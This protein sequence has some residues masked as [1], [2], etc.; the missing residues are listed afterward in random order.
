MWF[1]L[2]LEKDFSRGLNSVLH[3]LACGFRQNF[4]VLRQALLS[5][6][7]LIYP[8]CL[9][10]FIPLWLE[11]ILPI[12][13]VLLNW[14][15]FVLWPNIWSVLKNIPDLLEKNVFCY[16]WRRNSIYFNLLGILKYLE[17]NLVALLTYK[18]KLTYFNPFFFL[19]SFSCSA[20]LENFPLLNNVSPIN[21][22]I[23]TVNLCLWYPILVS[24]N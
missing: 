8:L 22:L 12:I 1:F 13:S 18:T 9:P 16:C 6:V 20:L 17:V 23:S 4:L 7:F 11:N 5:E 10:N 21:T 15:T 24:I 2:F 19:Y 14:L 3:L